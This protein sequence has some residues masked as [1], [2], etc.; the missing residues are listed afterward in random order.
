MTFD[1]RGTPEPFYSQSPL[2]ICLISI[3]TTQ[4]DGVFDRAPRRQASLTGLV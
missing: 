2:G 1:R 4:Y 3:Q